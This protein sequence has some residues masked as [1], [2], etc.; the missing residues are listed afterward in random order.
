MS[1]E[2]NSKMES[3]GG[4]NVKGFEDNKEDKDE[5]IGIGF[6]GSFHL[7]A[8]KGGLIDRLFAKLEDYKADL[9]K[10]QVRPLL[11]DLIQMDD[12]VNKLIRSFAEKPAGE[13]T[14]TDMV[15][16]FETFSQD[17]EQ[18]LFRH[19]IE[20]FQEE[21]EVFNPQRQRVLKPVPTSD[22]HLDRT[23][24]QRVRKGFA[25]EGQVVRRE[26]VDVYVYVNPENEGKSNE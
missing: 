10:S 14:V 19:G 24:A 2:K 13:L 11:L 16:V 15:K 23:I 9:W 5:L 20:A 4:T 1:E 17:L 25:R 8:N 12:D 7:S 26:F 22:P 3:L 21:S 18:Q 6:R